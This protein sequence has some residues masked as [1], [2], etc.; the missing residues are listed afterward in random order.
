MTDQI[1]DATTFNAE[2][3][4]YSAPKSTQQGAK[5]VNVLHKKTKRGITLTLP[6]FLTWGLAD[7]VDSATGVGDGR[8]SLSIQFPSGEYDTPQTAACLEN[9]KNLESKFLADAIVNSKDWF[10]KVHKS[11]EV[12]AALWTE[13]LKYPKNKFSKDTDYTKAPTMRLKMP[14]DKKGVFDCEI[15][16]EEGELLFPCADKDNSYVLELI[17]KGTIISCLI[18]L[19]AIWFINGKFSASWKFVQGVVQKPKNLSLKGQC[20]I[21]VNAQDKEKFK[22]Q[23]VPSEVEEV[24]VSTIVDDSDEETEEPV[25]VFTPSSEIQIQIPEPVQAHVSAPVVQTP[26]VVEEPKKVV[27]KVVK[28]KE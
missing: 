9:F 23:V 11:P 24:V 7:F 1:I 2:D 22:S 6:P 8:Y 16:S 21:S 19:S 27:K 5:F 4:I 20:W 18:Q 17:K 15:Y 13:M 25:T 10:G 26:V 28:K 14:Q 3:V 12:I